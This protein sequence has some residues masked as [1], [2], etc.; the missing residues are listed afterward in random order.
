M[1][2]PIYD[3]IITHCKSGDR[4][5]QRELYRL[6]SP[7]MFAI[8]VR[9]MGD[10]TAAEDVLQD[11]FVTLFSKIETFSDKGSFEGWAKRIFINTALM[12]LRKNDA[13]KMSDSLDNADWMTSDEPC[14]VQDIGYKELLRQIASLPTCYRTI[15]NMYAIEGYS[16]NDIAETLG[17]SSVAS[18]S[19]LNRARAML[20]ERIKKIRDARER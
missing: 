6:L 4:S 9:Y 5:A 7:K 14:P 19:R 2:T 20:Q 3:D 13:L 10:R 16:H 18:R 11:G 12:S 1:N 8:C 17:I 15:F